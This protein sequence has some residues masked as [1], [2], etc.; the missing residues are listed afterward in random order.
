[1][2]AL[3]LAVLLLMAGKGQYRDFGDFHLPAD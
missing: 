2:I 1:M 3:E